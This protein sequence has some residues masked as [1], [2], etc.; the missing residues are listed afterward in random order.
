MLRS[1]VSRAG[2]ERVGW[3]P[4]PLTAPPQWGSL[5]SVL[6]N[7]QPGWDVHSRDGPNGDGPSS[8]WAPRWTWIPSRARYGTGGGGYCM[9]QDRVSRQFTSSFKYVGLCSGEN[10]CHNL[11]WT[12]AVAGSIPSA[13]CTLAPHASHTRLPHVLQ[14]ERHFLC[15]CRRPSRQS[16]PSERHELHEAGGGGGDALVGHVDS[17]DRVAHHLIDTFSC[18]CE[19]GRGTRVCV[20][21]TQ[22][23]SVD[24]PTSTTGARHP[25]L[26][27]WRRRPSKLCVLS[28]N[29]ILFPFLSLFFLLRQFLCSC[30]HF[31]L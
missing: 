29:Y 21:G 16:L 1:D 13:F 30:E 2:W 4:H 23:P 6:P 27:L 17:P 25:Q 8:R 24:K 22:L 14:C 31:L 11:G 12:C 20:S 19:G 7:T 28:R 3:R 18:P 9:E 15:P 5:K 10:S 26:R